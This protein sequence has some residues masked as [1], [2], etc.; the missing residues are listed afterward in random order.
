[1]NNHVNGIIR[2]ENSK[3]PEGK[4][5]S[6]GVEILQKTNNSK[7]GKSG[8]VDIEKINSMPNTGNREHRGVTRDY[9]TS[10]ALKSVSFSLISDDDIR[11]FNVPSMSVKKKARIEDQEILISYF[12][13]SYFIRVKQ[14]SEF[15]YLCAKKFNV[16]PDSMFII[17]KYL[18]RAYT[19]D[20]RIILTKP[21][22]FGTSEETDSGIGCWIVR[23]EKGI[24]EI[25]SCSNQL[26]K[27]RIFTKD[28]DSEGYY[29]PLKIERNMKFCFKN[30]IYSM[31]TEQA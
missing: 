15:V 6:H 1:M 23:E 9:L 18:I 30:K 12:N 21:E 24:R 22:I 4:F 31:E 27:K 14:N 10:K 7:Q 19:Q 2:K 3:Q 28:I 25:I 11:K 16:I 5:V 26:I 29:Y 17:G 13:Q 8:K 20:N